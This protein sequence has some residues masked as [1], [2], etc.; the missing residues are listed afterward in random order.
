MQ[1]QSALQ[2][3]RFALSSAAERMHDEASPCDKGRFDLHDERQ[4]LGAARDAGFSCPKCASRS[5]SML[6]TVYRNGASEQW[7]PPREME[8]KGWLFL[9]LGSAF[10]LMAQAEPGWMRDTLAAIATGAALIGCRATLY[11][12]RRL[13]GIRD[14]WRKSAM[15]PRCGHVFLAQS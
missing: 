11:N 7:A 4:W 1:R 15:C 6:D 3:T 14:C 8:V 13:P 2:L 5:G 12:I 10:A 9:G